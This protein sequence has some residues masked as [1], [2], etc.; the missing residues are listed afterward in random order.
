MD[1]QLIIALLFGLIAFIYIGK[2]MIKQL[3]RIEKDPKCGNCPVPEGIQKIGN[4][5]EDS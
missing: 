5:K 2:Q 4:K 1:I 3:T